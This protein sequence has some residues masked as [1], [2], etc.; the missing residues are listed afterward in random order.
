MVILS[1]PRYAAW[2]YGLDP[3]H[4]V[5]QPGI[6]FNPDNFCGCSGPYFVSQGMV[7]NNEKWALKTTNNGT[8]EQFKCI[9]HARRKY[10][11]SLKEVLTEELSHDESGFGFRTY[12]V[13]TDGACINNGYANAIAGA[14]VYFGKNNPKNRS[15]RLNGSH[16][17]SQTAELAAIYFALRCI[18]DEK[19]DK[20][21]VLYTDSDYSLKCLTVWYKT[22]ERNGSTPRD[23]LWPI[24]NLSRTSSCICAVVLG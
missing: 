4:I 13:Y 20:D 2:K 8:L 5:P 9:K 18:V 6:P 15:L 23:S 7:F 3:E 16:H 22:W 19:A 14:G 21:Y 24:N 10:G 12:E 17:T 1:D 11:N